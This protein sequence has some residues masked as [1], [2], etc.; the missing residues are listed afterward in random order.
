M[1]RTHT[2]IVAYTHKIALRA[3]RNEEPTIV[4]E[5]DLSSRVY[6][7]LSPIVNAA[8]KLDDIF[9]RFPALRTYSYTELASK[10]N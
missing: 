9:G 7:E 3:R 6:G 8:F 1:D 4:S 2:P 5:P 10:G